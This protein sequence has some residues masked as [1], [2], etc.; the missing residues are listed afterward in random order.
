MNARKLLEAY[1]G[2]ENPRAMPP[3]QLLEAAAPKAF[4]A[5]GAVLDLH[6]PVSWFTECMDHSRDEDADH[7]HFYVGADGDVWACE[8]TREPNVCQGCTP[9]CADDD[10]HPPVP[11]PCPTVQAITTALETAP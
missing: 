2:R 10:E 1:A 8:D 11:Y 4:A 9:D 6:K 7:E 5:I 3:F